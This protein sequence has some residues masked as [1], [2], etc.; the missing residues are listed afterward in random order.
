MVLIRPA[1]GHGPLKDSLALAWDR[2]IVV[3]MKN[4]L[5]IVRTRGWL[6]ALLVAIIILLAIGALANP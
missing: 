3:M 5:W 6:T 2:A 1:A 4:Q